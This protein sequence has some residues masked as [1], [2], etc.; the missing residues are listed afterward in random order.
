M[1]ECLLISILF[2]FSL[3]VSSS[4]LPTIKSTLRFG[5]K[6]PSSADFDGELYPWESFSFG[7]GKVWRWWSPASSLAER[8]YSSSSSYP[9]DR[10]P[11]E[12]VLSIDFWSVLFLNGLSKFPNLTVPPNMGDCCGLL[13]PKGSL[14]FLNVNPCTKLLVLCL[15]LFF[16]GASLILISYSFSF[17][18]SSAYSLIMASFGSSLILG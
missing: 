16:G 3:A 10:A 17:F 8:L 18:I 1:G 4:K 12:L 11:F 6:P 13:T 15:T 14:G 2:I 7:V 9:C 5:L